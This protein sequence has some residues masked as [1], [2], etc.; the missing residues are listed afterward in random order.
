MKI[1]ERIFH[2]CNGN[3]VYIEGSRFPE[4]GTTNGGEVWRNYR[5]SVCK[6]LYTTCGSK[7]HKIYF[8]QQMPSRHLI[9]N[10]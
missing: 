1:L 7:L 9:D 4:T 5:C 6:R 10:I 8:P 3:L 2:N